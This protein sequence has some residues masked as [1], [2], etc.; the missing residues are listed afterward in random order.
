[1]LCLSLAEGEILPAELT[2]QQRNLLE[3]TNKSKQQKYGTLRNRG[4][5]RLSSS[6]SS[7][8]F[9]YFS[10]IDIFSEKN[11]FFHSIVLATE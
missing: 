5:Q 3:E 1:M 10:N 11:V 7:R 9:Y 4:L 8:M 6:S 2:A